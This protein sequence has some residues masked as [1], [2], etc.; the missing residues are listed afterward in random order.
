MFDIKTDKARIW[1]KDF[2]GK[3]GE[4]YKYTTSISR[5]NDDGGYVNAYM[6]I[7]FARKCDVPEKIDNGAICAFE[8]FLSVESYKDKD[9]N[10]RNQPMIVA[11]SVK[12]DDAS[13]G[14][15]SFSQAEVEIPF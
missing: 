14:V 3:N 12:F 8:G 13:I 4:F 5:K 11:M 6:P 2:Q 7:R 9:G 10:E 15:D 1:R